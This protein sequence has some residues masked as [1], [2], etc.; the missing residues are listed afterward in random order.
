MQSIRSCAALLF[1]C[2]GALTAASTDSCYASFRDGELRI[3]NARIERRWRVDRGR[4]YP[5]SFRDLS[6]GAEWLAGASVQP[7]PSV[8]AAVAALTPAFSSRTER[9]NPV[10]SEALVAELAFAGPTPIVYRFRIFPD[11]A[12][13]SIQ[14]VRGTDGREGASAPAERAGGIETNPAGERQ[15][16]SDVLDALTL[17]PQHIR[18]TQVDL[19]DQTDIHNELVF[20]RE[21]LMQ[22]NERIRLPGNLFVVENTLT[23]AGLVF[24]KQAPLPHARA[25]RSEIDFDVDPATHRVALLGAAYPGV[26]LAYTGGR[27]GRTFALQQYQRQLRTYDPKR[28]V[29]FLS[30]TWGDRSRDSRI[31][32]EFMAREIDAGARLGVDVIQIDDGWQHGRS[33]NS[34]SAGGVWNGFWAADPNFWTVD[35]KR[36]PEGLAPLVSRARQSGM[37]FGL[38]FAPDSSKEFANWERDAAQLTGFWRDLGVRYFKIDG[39]KSLTPLCEKR[40]S[41]MFQRVLAESR[42]EVAFD[43]DVTA[44]TRPGYFGSMHTGP[45]FVENRYTDWQ[46]YWPHQTLRNLWKLAQYVDPRRLRIEFLN[47]ARNRERY[48]GD[49]LAPARYSPAYLFATTMFANPLGWFE[50][51]NLPPAYFAELPPLVAQW[52]RER[53]AIFRGTILP[54]GDVPDG[55]SWTGFASVAEDRRSAYLLVFRELNDA[56]QWSLTVPLLESGPYRASV[57][58]GSGT[59][60]TAGDSV[61]ISIPQPQNFLWLRLSR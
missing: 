43:L 33:V 59:A 6:S 16:L 28:D 57:L 34:A 52:K 31:T 9:A 22:N 21:W 44:E 47:N 2:A 46:R 54:V 49:P 60:E 41:G 55:T 50:M 20:E 40:L 56:A 51:S 18:I 61:R 48:S 27:A 24:L 3:G 58:A 26:T 29:R 15:L 37:Q 14:V 12:G 11:A 17:A 23:R 35:S 36:F 32:A 53:E 1:V 42:G 13:V 10:E 4:L 19:V 39:V 7:S 8:P 38:W 45:L 30:N 25:V 5:T